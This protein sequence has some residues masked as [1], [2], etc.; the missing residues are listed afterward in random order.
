VGPFL[1][2]RPQRLFPDVLGGNPHRPS[3]PHSFP[4]GPVPPGLLSQSFSPA[5]P[6]Q[7]RAPPALGLRR[8]QRVL[9]FPQ[10]PNIIRCG[11]KGVS[12]LRFKWGTYP[13][14][15]V[16]KGGGDSSSRLGF[17]L[18]QHFVFPRIVTWTSN[19]VSH[20]F[21]P[22]PPRNTPAPFCQFFPFSGPCC[23]FFLPTFPPF[24]SFFIELWSHATFPV[25]ESFKGSPKI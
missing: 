12:F 21:A 7:R 3:A 16:L 20:N 11:G 17:G 13:V 25:M 24:F 4:P 15:H 14:P 8:R 19:P 1:G 10:R 6:L 22:S 18:R 5:K 23:G 9:Q 2:R